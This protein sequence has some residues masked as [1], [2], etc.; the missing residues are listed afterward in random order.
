MGRLVAD[1]RALATE[2]P[3]PADA[4]D[5]LAQVDRETATEP[6][7]PPLPR[8]RRGPLLPDSLLNILDRDTDGGEPR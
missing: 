4:A 1:I 8:Q 3:A 5:I 6:T 7:R 2:Y